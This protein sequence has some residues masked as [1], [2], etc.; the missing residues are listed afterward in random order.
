MNTRIDDQDGQVVDCDADINLLDE[1]LP[2]A[3]IPGFDFELKGKYPCAC[4]SRHKPREV[5]MTERKNRETT[6]AII[7]QSNPTRSPVATFPTEILST[8]FTLSVAESPF[9]N[10]G[11]GETRTTESI[12]AQV[13]ARWRWIA[14]DTPALWTTFRFR[15]GDPKKWTCWMLVFLRLQT[16]LKRSGQRPVDLWLEVTSQWVAE[17]FLE[18]FMDH[19]PRWRCVSM[20]LPQESL[21]PYAPVLSALAD[22]GADNLESLEV[23]ILQYDKL[24]L[25]A[26]PVEKS[27]RGVPKLKHV[28]MDTKAFRLC[29][30]PLHSIT[31]LHLETW[32]TYRPQISWQTFRAI[33]TSPTLKNLTL[34]GGK[35]FDNRDDAERLTTSIERFVCDDDGIAGWMWDALDAPHLKTV[36]IKNFANQIHP[37]IIDGKDH[38]PSLTSIVFIDCAITQGAWQLS[39]LLQDTLRTSQTSWMPG[40]L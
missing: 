15:E 21:R 32:C 5:Y 22:A 10:G 11:L 9:V 35:I 3:M 7:T 34:D 27:L 30:P 8:I 38:F 14:L 24:E 13:C 6:E 4:G 39:E 16:Y 25:F 31:T 20:R 1:D 19:L 2:A 23:S 12:I 29:K 37:Q 18:K 17:W 40:A 26:E 36:I 28:K 33:V